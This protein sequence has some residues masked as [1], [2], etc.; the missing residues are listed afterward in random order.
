MRIATSVILLRTSAFVAALDYLIAPYQIR[1][2]RRPVLRPDVVSMSMGGL[3]SRAWAEVVNRAYEAGHLPGHR[4]GQQFS[5]V[6]AIHRLSGSL[7]AGHRRL[8]RH[9]QWRSLYPR[10]G[11]VSRMAGNLWA[12][13]QDGHG[14]GGLYPQ[15]ALGR[16]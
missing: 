12:G 10:Q 15:Y 9:G 1:L 7:S 14:P 8:R 2:T 6:A 13:Q 3:A 5:R 11:A 4:G 16:D